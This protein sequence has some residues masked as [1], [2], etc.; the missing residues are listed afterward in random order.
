MR[1]GPGRC[2]RVLVCWQEMIAR[3]TRLGQI[4]YWWMLSSGCLIRS[5]TS[6]TTTNAMT[7]IATPAARESL[8]FQG[9]II[10]G[11]SYPF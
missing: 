4:R 2:K 3:A 7:I 6:T 5:G 8:V 11:T 9:L 1:Q 10:G